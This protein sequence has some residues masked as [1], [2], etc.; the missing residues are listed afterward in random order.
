M[1]ENPV[2]TDM[3]GLP[4]AGELRRRGLELGLAAVGITSPEVLEP[5]RSAITSRKRDGLNGTMQFTYRNPIRSSE[6]RRRMPS[7][8]ALVVAALRYGSEPEH[9]DVEAQREPTGP[10]WAGR[11]ARYVWSDHYG[12]LAQLLEEL[13][14][15]LVEAGFKA[16]VIIDSNH[17]VD[18]NV[19]W[20]AGLGWYGKNSNLLLPGAGS[21]YVLGSILTDA[22]LDHADVPMVDGCGPCSRCIDECPTR[23]IIAPGVVDA[24]RCIAWLVQAAEPIPI[25]FRV[26]VGDRIYGCDDC[27]EVC[28]PNLDPSAAVEAHELR[29]DIGWILTADND[30]IVERHGAWYVAN[31]DVDVIRR[32]AL[33]VLGNTAEPEWGIDGV[34][35]LLRR[36]L[37]SENSLLR[38]HAVWATRR[39]GLDPT[40][41]GNGIGVE[42]A[43]PQCC[44]GSDRSACLDPALHDELLAPVEPRFSSDQWAEGVA[45]R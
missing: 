29:A 17:L 2:T 12:R 13:A 34:T 18:R 11:I 9:Q 39:L 43:L 24:R 38:N 5:A 15:P 21:W 3:V 44:A 30:A 8:N 6:P 1:V 42:I 14:T 26:A 37:A 41:R 28:P 25:E 20:R 35:E 32:S 27:Q 10:R 45:V 40:V 33:V 23:A 16:Q 22:P 19:A 4:T 31:R 36:H 7:A